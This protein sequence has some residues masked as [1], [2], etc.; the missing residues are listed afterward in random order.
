MLRQMNEQDGYVLIVVDMQPDQA[1]ASDSK[2]L[3]AV[4]REIEEAKRRQLP[5]IVL[6]FPEQNQLLKIRNEAEEAGKP[7]PI[8][9]TEVEHPLTLPSVMK[10]LDGYEHKTVRQKFDFSGAME[11]A[12]ACYDRSWPKTAFRLVGV[13]AFSCVLRTAEGLCELNPYARLEVIQDAC[14]YEPRWGANW[15]KFDGVATVVPPAPKA[16]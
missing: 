15:F 6:E 11:V 9:R 5:I 2:I 10:L 8:G 16:A 14:G 1:A 13:Y 3:R 12:Y 4:C 7:F